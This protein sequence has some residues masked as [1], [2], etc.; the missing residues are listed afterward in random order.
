MRFQRNRSEP[1]RAHS[2]IICPGNLPCRLRL[3]PYAARRLHGNQKWKDQ[4]KKTKLAITSAALL[5]A[6][7]LFAAAQGT[8]PGGQRSEDPPQG[9]NSGNP[10][11]GSVNS[12]ESTM[13][14]GTVGSGAQTKS[15]SKMNAQPGG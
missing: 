10:S 8:Q 12:P 11:E 6:G 13:P 1:A 14:Q 3:T 9:S 7:T 2:I 5:L 4:M 15:K